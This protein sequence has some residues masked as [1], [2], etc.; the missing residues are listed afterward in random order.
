[1]SRINKFILAGILV[2]GMPAAMVCAE[3]AAVPKP[4]DLTAGGEKDKSHDWLLGP[5]GLRGWMFTLKGRT[6]AA[7]QI[8]VTAVE[9]DSPADGIFSTNDVIL[10]VEGKPFKADARIQFGNAITAAETKKGGGR[11]RLI[12]WRQGL[13]TNVDLKLKVLGA[14]SDTAPYDCPKSK[15][16]FEQGCR[17]IAK[18]GLESGGQ[19]GQYVNALA[20]LAS[21]KEEYRPLLADCTKKMAAGMRNGDGCWGM[22]YANLFLAE[23]VLATGDEAM[24]AELKRTT[25][26][27]VD[28]QSTYGTWGHYPRLP[29]GH[30]PGYGP[31]N[32]IGLAMTLSMALARQ[33]GVA[34]PAL[35]AAI[36]KSTN[37]LRW[38]VNK[39]AIPYG[40]HPPEPMH[41]DSG[42]CSLAAV[43]FDLLGDREATSFFARMGTAAY[44]ERE[45]G[46]CGNWFNMLWALPGVSRCGPLATGAYLKEQSWYYDLARNWQGGFEYQQIDPSD[47]GGNYNGWDL[48]GTYLMSFGLPLKSLYVMGK[49]PCTVPPLNREEVKAVIHAGRDAYSIN[50]RNGYNARK[51]RELM[52][53]LASWS[54]IMRK[55][56]AKALALRKGDFVPALLKMLA[57]SDPYA[58]YGACEALGCLG[59]QADAAAPQLRALLKDPD[60]WLR[61]LACY[62]LPNLGPEARLA[63]VNDLL[64]LAASSNPADPRRMV[65]RAV[66]SS[67]FAPYDTGDTPAI[68]AESI[69]G[70]D[71]QLLYPAVR[72][73]LENDDSVARW[74][75]SAIYDKLTDR[76]AAELLPAIVKAAEELAP[77][78]EWYSYGP[79]L[80]GEDLLSRLHIREGMQMSV[81]HLLVSQWGM[82]ARIEKCPVYL[83][84]YGAQAKAVLPQLQALRLGRKGDGVFQKCMDEIEASTES[85]TLVDLKEFIEKASAGGAVSTDTK[86]VK[87]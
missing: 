61:S 51:T 72:S 34:D 37:F 50:G 8:L 75:P 71:R 9:K 38:Y 23:Y 2:M 48:T 25:M 10:G 67:L 78:N 63:S 12:R 84:R 31:M 35:D 45:Q 26:Y 82:F 77:S 6:T 49:K 13:S 15:A 16:I 7:R 29:N 3:E 55:R 57:G 44:D 76:D 20:L 83:A 65:Q 81:D 66:G 56:S 62:A 5:T 68:L 85:P 46:H 52:A 1:M 70:V 21:G 32:Q 80:A 41:E 17:R 87:P 43:L 39:G 28:A 69:E 18:R 60:P 54:P 79:W 11:L 19:L 22:S 30:A 40:D 27:V 24:R 14:Y 58:R 53:G 36:A 42:K 59:P 64:R 47:E 74:T 86:K 73:L 33:A 4:P